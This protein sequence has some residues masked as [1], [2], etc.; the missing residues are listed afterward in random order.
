MK[1]T[2]AKLITKDIFNTLLLINLL[3]VST[4]SVARPSDAEMTQNLLNTVQKQQYV[5]QA[6]NVIDNGSP[7]LKLEEAYKHLMIIKICVKVRSG[8][9]AQAI[10]APEYKATKNNAKNIEDHL[11]PDLTK[12][13]DD[14]WST[15]G[16]RISDANLTSAFRNLPFNNL[17][18]EC[19]NILYV[20]RFY[21][22]QLLGKEEMLKDF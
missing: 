18:T 12:S 6:Q 5:K 14:I 15:A 4:L 2:V 10:S 20:N 16:K 9:V 11:K 7:D 22:E 17:K 21:T 8:Y 19:E 3:G 1:I 13:T